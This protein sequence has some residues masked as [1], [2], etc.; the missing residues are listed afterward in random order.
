MISIFQ[1][2]FSA[3]YHV[4]NSIGRDMPDC[5]PCS[6]PVHFFFSSSFFFV[7][8]GIPVAVSPLNPRERKAWY[9]PAQ[10]KAHN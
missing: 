4:R 1:D 8:G 3:R 9:G 10:P 2:K 6:F 7:E 5:R